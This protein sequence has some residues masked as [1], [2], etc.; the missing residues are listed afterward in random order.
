MFAEDYTTLMEEFASHGY[1]VAAISH[2]GIN[3]VAYP[4]GAIGTEWT[5]W[6]APQGLSMSLEP[7]SLRLSWQ[8]FRSRDLYL[9]ADVRFVIQS[10][11][12]PDMSPFAVALDTSKVGVLGHST[13]GAVAAAAASDA[14]RTGIRALLVYDV[15]L[16][17]ALFDAPI[18]VPF[19]LMRTSATNY[20]PGWSELQVETFSHL[21]S[22]GFDVRVLGASHQ[23]FSDRL[24]LAART[25]D[26]RVALEI[27]LK[28]IAE[29]SLA[30]FDRYLRRRNTAL[31]DVSS[32]GSSGVE[33][34][35]YS[36]RP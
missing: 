13:G 33:V 27:H 19:M 14:D 4:D 34:K 5:G 3:L 29:Y 21:A 20:P 1:V 6:R 26:A 18:P 2:P 15:I 22:D 31:L 36:K 17:G 23:S 30:F 24:L 7:D 10:L 32:S 35:H 9:A 8:F 25:P 16:P 28:R 11:E 12:S